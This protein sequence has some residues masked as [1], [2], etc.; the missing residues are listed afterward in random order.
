MVDE[1]LVL[2]AGDAL[3]GAELDEIGKHVAQQLLDIGA[4]QG[5]GN[6]ADQQ[7]LLAGDLHAAGRGRQTPPPAPP[8]VRLARLT[9]TL[10]GTSSGWLRIPC[11]SRACLRRS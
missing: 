5:H 8:P 3:R 1:Q 11:S 6:L 2:V 4:V 7:T 9:A 10:C